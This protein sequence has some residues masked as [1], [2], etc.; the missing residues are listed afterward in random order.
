MARRSRVGEGVASLSER[1]ARSPPTQIRGDQ[2]KRRVDVHQH[3]AG[4][5]PKRPDTLMR[6]PSIAGGVLPSPLLKVVVTA[7]DL[8]GQPDAVAV[9]I[10]DVG[11]ERVLPPETQTL[12]SVRPENPPEGDLGGRHRLPVSTCSHE[13]AGC[14][15]H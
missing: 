11:T 7:I 1:I 2:S 10:E 13:G 4:R 14:I 6:H 3:Q 15:L 8:D 9:E 12:E 5:K